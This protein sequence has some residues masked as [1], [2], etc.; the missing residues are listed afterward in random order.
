M[1]TIII[2]IIFSLFSITVYSQDGWSSWT[3]T[4]CYKG[5]DFRVKKTEYNEHAKKYR[6][7]VQFRNR[8]QENI[9]FSCTAV[10]PSE[11]SKI[12]SSNKTTDRM[13]AKGN[14]GTTGT[15]FLVDAPSDIYVHVNKV[16]IGKDTWEGGYYDCDI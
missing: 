1:K 7:S 9:H 8:Y 15:Y 2:S 5:L 10:K 14:G 11:R 13:H 6:W 3:Q 4:D 16:K 12:R